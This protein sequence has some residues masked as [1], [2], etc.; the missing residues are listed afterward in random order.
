L[1]GKEKL[2]LLG[3]S[4]VYLVGAFVLSGLVAFLL[5][6]L[7]LPPGSGMLRIAA[8]QT[9]ALLIGFGLATWVIGMR[10]LRFSRQDFEQLEPDR[11][12]ARRF[13][14]LGWGMAAGA[15]L[16]ALAMLVAV[17]VGHAGWQT[18]PTGAG[19]WLGATGLTAAV[20]LPAALAEELAFRGVPLLALS[21][22]FGRY[23]AMI[24]LAVVF[25][26][27]HLENP[28]VTWLALANIAL[29]GVF[30]ALVFFTPGGLWTSTGAHL[31]WNLTL[32]GLGA[33]VSGLPLA[34]PWLSYSPGE[35]GWLTGGAFGPEGGVVA[36][37]CLLGGSFLMARATRGKKE[38]A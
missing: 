21:R 4:L 3:W 20:L 7:L 29:A 36:S 11:A 32:A 8:V 34:I 37:A 15:L 16:G 22:A 1:T 6:R 25:A 13:G 5:G 9:V 19:A 28:S 30:L 17:P 24:G 33:P 10:V 18:D 14:R 12:A 27:A 31:G 26:L 38:A 35:P 2:R 23:P